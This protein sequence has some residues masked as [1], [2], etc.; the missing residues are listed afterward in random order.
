MADT[1]THDPDSNSTMPPTA[2]ETTIL[3][4]SG[5]ETIKPMNRENDEDDFVLGYMCLVDFECE[6]GAALDGN[7][8]YPSERSLREHMPCVEDC[9]IVEVKVS[10]SRLIRPGRLFEEEA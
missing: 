2:E 8:V 4:E 10:F 5:S 3:G 6:I 9:G 7:K 1:M